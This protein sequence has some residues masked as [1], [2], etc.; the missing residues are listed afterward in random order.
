M[1]RVIVLASILFFVLL[2][3]AT[4]YVTKVPL[5]PAIQIN[6]ENQPTIGDQMAPVHIV[7]FEEPKCYMCQRF[8]KTI[9]PLIKKELIDTNI[10][11]YSVITVSFLPGSLSAAEALICS[12]NQDPGYPNPELFFSFLDYMYRH[13][14][15]EHT[16]WA[17][18]DTLLSMAKAAS[19]AINLEK[20]KTC[21]ERDDYRI[22]VVKNTNYG[23]ELMGGVVYTPT[24]YVNGMRAESNSYDH[25]KDLVKAALKQRGKK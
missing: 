10:A 22:T 13:Q 9:F 17:Q 24:I 12:Y 11:K 14:P 16:D 18:I 5:P 2:S 7:V 4:V 15:D 25:I 19:L 21:V 3:I 23:K 8:T 20:L 6:T 1:N